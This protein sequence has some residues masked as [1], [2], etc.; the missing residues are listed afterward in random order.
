V[1]YFNRYAYT[2]NDPVNAIDPDGQFFGAI[3]KLAKLAVKGGDLGATFAGAAQDVGTIFSSDASGLERL[4]AVASLATEVVS[5]VSAR[6]AKAGLRAVRGCCFVAGTEILTD[7]G[8]LPI[9][10]IRVGDRVM[11]HD[12]ETGETSFKPVT[13]LFVNDEDAVWELVVETTNGTSEIHRVTDNH[14]YFVEGQGWVEVADL[15]VGM[16]IA[17]ME[18]DPVTLSSIVKTGKVERTF[19]FEVADFH[20]YFVGDQHVLVHNCGGLLPKPP[21]GQGSVPKGQRDPQRRF[22]NTQQ[23]QMVD[24][25]GGKCANGCGTDIDVSNSDGHHVTRHADG[26]ATTL[27]NGAQV[28]KDCHKDLHSRGQ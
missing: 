4:G 8:M 2:A 16:S 18:G 21:R 13:T 6:D 9:E 19:N 7:R 23:Q 24:R 1:Q 5:P 3:G 17:T 12:P 28:C 27:E 25:Q 14:P 10:Q 11:A 22:S 26:G 20:T 15:V